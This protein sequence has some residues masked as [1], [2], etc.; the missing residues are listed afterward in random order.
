[1]ALSNDKEILSHAVSM[2]INYVETGSSTG[3]SR[4]QIIN[5]AK[6]DKDMQRVANNLPPLTTEQLMFLSKLRDVRT[7]V[8]NGDIQL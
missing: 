7:R 2:W 1:M 6:G 5:M 4:D 3:P 8:L